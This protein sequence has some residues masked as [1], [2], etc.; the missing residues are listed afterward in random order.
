M[1]Y[2]T[3]LALLQAVMLEYPQYYA[4]KEPPYEYEFERLPM[5]LILGDS[6]LRKD[7]EAGVAISLLEK[8]WQPELTEFKQIRKKYLLY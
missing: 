3:S 5:D 8:Q 2:R 1:P 4:H 7:L 6:A